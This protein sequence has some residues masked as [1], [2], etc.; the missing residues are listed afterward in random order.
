VLNS[1]SH[2][3]SQ[4]GDAHFEALEREQYGRILA[5]TGCG[6]RER[7]SEI[8]GKAGADFKQ[9]QFSYYPDG[10]RLL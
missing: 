1:R 8:D 2:G 5:S 10:D 4:L 3:K 7:T 6:R 9:L